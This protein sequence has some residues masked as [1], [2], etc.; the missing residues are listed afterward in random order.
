MTYS[1]LKRSGSLVVHHVIS[2]ARAPELALEP[3]NLVTLCWDHHVAVH[4]NVELATQR[5]FL[6]SVSPN[7]PPEMKSHKENS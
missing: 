2:R 4:A 6:K 1:T 3:S 5:G 7:P